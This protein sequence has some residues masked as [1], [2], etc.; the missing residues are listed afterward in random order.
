MVNYPYA[1]SFI[2]AMPAWPVNASC[3]AALALAPSADQD[4]VR[5]IQAAATVYYNYT[6]E[7]PGCYN[8]TNP[9]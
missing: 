1:T 2:F 8:T 9:N 7:I 5:A 6:G 3:D 4:Y